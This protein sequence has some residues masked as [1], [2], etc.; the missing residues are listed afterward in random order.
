MNS[1]LFL[2]TTNMAK[3][4]LRYRNIF[5]TAFLIISILSFAGLMRVRINFSFDK[6]FPDQDEDV[7]FFKAYEQWFPQNDQILYLALKSP[8]TTVF[9]I[10]FLERIADLQDSIQNVVFVDSLVSMISLPEI[11]RT[12]M[13]F[14]AK[15]LIQLT[16][17]DKLQNGRRKLLKDPLMR[18]AFVS[19]NEQWTSMFI[20]LNKSILDGASRDDTYD[21][22][23]RLTE[24][25]GFEYK[26][27]GVP[28]IRTEYVRKVTYELIFFVSLSLI[29]ILLFLYLTFKSW[30]GIVMPIMGVI[31]PV[32]WL[33]GIMG[34]LNIELDLLTTLLPSL[35]FIVGTSDII[36]LLAKYIQE[37]RKG[38][39]KVKALYIT[40]KEMGWITFLT[41]F[42]TAV[43]LA[44]L[45]T[46]ALLPIR[47]FGLYASLGVIL[48]FVITFLLLPSLL[49][50]IPEETIRKSDMKRAI[51]IP[52]DNLL[53]KIFELGSRKGKLIFTFAILISGVGLLG[54]TM[55]SRN[56]RLLDDVGENDPIRQQLDFFETEFT[57]V[58]NLEMGIQPKPGIDL[59]SLAFLKEIEKIET[60]IEKTGAC[61]AVVSLPDFYRRANYIWHFNRD[62]YN[63]LPTDTAFIREVQQLSVG[64]EPYQNLVRN[65]EGLTRIS[66][67]MRDLGSDSM[68]I[69]ASQLSAFTN[70]HTDTSL[71]TYRLTGTAVLFEKN[72]EY[73]TSGIFTSLLLSALI[74][75][76]AMGTLFRS[77]QML[78][79][80]FI[81]NLLPLLVLGG[82]M[83]FFGISLK[84]ST[85]IVIALAFGIA[86]DD[87][88]H[89]LGR[90]KIE[91]QR[92]STDR[93]EII[94]NTLLA[95]G[96]GLILTTFVLSAGFLLLIA[97]DFGGTFYVGLFCC[98]T[99]SF[100]LIADLLILPPILQK[101]MPEHYFVKKKSDPF[102]K[103]A[104][105]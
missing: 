59:H 96:E 40:I 73:L 66:A 10:P 65:D 23:K 63:V 91:L 52:W 77:W 50:F 105:T 51:S 9:S 84:A 72:N 94:R 71:Y 33:I 2:L 92:G 61:H 15:P 38:R 39:K 31:F 86:F 88:I 36:H 18:T 37:I 75:A 99:L 74:I 76:L 98:I 55:I 19:R 58:R 80:A 104:T 41:S 29:L 3:Y 48:A 70:R 62:K 24:A 17:H 81:P 101:Y 103:K 69:F 25:A 1:T 53:N 13:G 4:I 30:W 43:S 45:Q 32:V 26:I 49:M 6:F 8:D 90:L 60:F 12:A 82:I 85:V 78:L 46:S 5:L 34:W 14:S 21:E 93:K 42:S 7:R 57:G 22:I 68:A 11:K 20:S 35:L 27:S 87:T 56:I 28:G 83:G 89:F 16:S 100:A 64:S 102:V 67:R 97:S 95:C 54:T 44:S 47:I 79:I